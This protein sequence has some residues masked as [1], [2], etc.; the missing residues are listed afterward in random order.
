[1]DISQQAKQAR[2]LF[3]DSKLE[4]C[5][6]YID[7]LHFD[8]N[9]FQSY[10]FAQIY[11]GLSF[12][13][14]SQ[15]QQ[16][17]QCFLDLI[18]KCEEKNKNDSD[19]LDVIIQILYQWQNFDEDQMK[20]K[21]HNNNLYSCCENYKQKH[22][23]SQRYD[24]Y[25]YLFG[26]SVYNFIDYYPDKKHC[27]YLDN[28]I[29]C[30]GK[31]QQFNQE[32]IILIGWMQD[33]LGK[34]EEARKWYTVLELINPRYPG[35]ANN[36]ALTYEAMS[37]KKIAEEYFLKAVE[38][39]PNNSVILTNLA[40]HYQ[41][42]EQNEKAF[43]LYEKSIKANPQF[44]G[45]FI[46]YAK[47]LEDNQNIEKAKE[48]LLKGNQLNQSNTDILQQLVHLEVQ[49]SNY[50]KA[51]EYVDIIIQMNPN[52]GFFEYKFG[53]ALFDKNQYDLCQTQFLRCL[54]K[55]LNPML[56]GYAHSKLAYS[57]FSQFKFLKSFK[58]LMHLGNLDIEQ[59]EF[60]EELDG[61]G[62]ILDE[63]KEIS[64]Q[65]KVDILNSY[66]GIIQ[67]RYKQIQLSTQDKFFQCF[68]EQK[69]D[70]YRNTVTLIA[71]QKH[72]QSLLTF[73]SSYN[74]WDLFLA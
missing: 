21:K 26:V 65:K 42:N 33:Y 40:Y 55:N 49:E 4:E 56:V 64:L 32:S 48:V 72:I 34:H 47:L 71:Y 31:I 8:E 9:D 50:Q 46:S 62:Y 53:S 24:L 43:E 6:K 29:E 19:E 17:Q 44:I 74:Y 73:K 12:F 28:L 7:E 14:L 67:T 59:F 35:L 11:K 70:L 57:Y 22:E 1:M 36:I 16:G 68:L 39:C 23:Q 37:E 20:A 13:E 45:C 38:I 61:I 58:Q 18:S 51:Q 63:I 2:E 41:N 10:K 3:L 60:Q 5:L 66:Q 15:Q 27:S 30:Q 54:K 69:Q 25:I 52:E